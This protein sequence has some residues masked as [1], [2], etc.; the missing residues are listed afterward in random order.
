MFFLPN[1]LYRR[2]AF[3][4]RKNSLQK[5]TLYAT[6][7]SYAKLNY[8]KIDIINL[9][10][11]RP[12]IFDFLPNIKRHFHLKFRYCEKATKFKKITNLFLK[13]LHYVTYKVGDFFKIY[14][15]SLECLKFMLVFINTGQSKNKSCCTV[16]TIQ[17]N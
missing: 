16:H 11:I 15:A 13:L 5:M 10:Y 8:A 1:K 12:I 6:R 9:I 4:L 14:V 3:Q 2:E 7:G 17:C